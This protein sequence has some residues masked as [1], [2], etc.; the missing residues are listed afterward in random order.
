MEP[1]IL[2]NCTSTWYRQ[3]VGADIYES[4]SD[5]SSIRS[6]AVHP[7]P[8][9]RGLHVLRG[10]IFA[11]WTATISGICL[12]LWRDWRMLLLVSDGIH[13][14]RNKVSFDLKL[15]REN[16]SVMFRNYS[17][18]FEEAET[19]KGIAIALKEGKTVSDLV[20]KFRT[21]LALDLMMDFVNTETV[22]VL[23]KANG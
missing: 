22:R 18:F 7:P 19:D 10:A 20:K 8:E 13:R 5:P 3:R 23:H 15:Y 21:Y 12:T 4:G 17:D 16:T 14:M 6:M 11:F 1:R 2:A 9:I